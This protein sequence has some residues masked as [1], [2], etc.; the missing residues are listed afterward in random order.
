MAPFPQR[1]LSCYRPIFGGDTEILILEFRGFKTL[2]YQFLPVSSY[3]SSIM[4]KVKT[5][6]ECPLLFR[7][8]NFELDA[9]RRPVGFA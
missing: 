1:V 7:I 2:A 5:V 4:D 8:V 3:R 9:G 6:S